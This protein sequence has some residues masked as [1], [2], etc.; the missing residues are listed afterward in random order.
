MATQVEQKDVVLA[1]FAAGIALAGFALVFQGIY[2]AFAAFVAFTQAQR[3]TFRPYFKV[4]VGTCIA[5]LV[6]TSS[7]RSYRLLWH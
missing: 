5:H 3:N 6:P 4:T 2:F 1:I 7:P